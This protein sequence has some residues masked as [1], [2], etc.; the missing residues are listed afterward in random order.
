M[1]R[2]IAQREGDVQNIF[3]GVMAYMLTYYY[4][5]LPL[6]PFEVDLRRM[7]QA[8]M[9]CGQN[10]SIAFIEV[11]GQC[12]ENLMGRG[13]GNP[14]DLTGSWLG[15]PDQLIADT[16]VQKQRKCEIQVYVCRQYLA[17]HFEDLQLALRMS[18]KLGPIFGS[19]N[20]TGVFV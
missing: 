4:S 18:D 16:R 3:L 15:D 14:T 2:T 9:E 11:R 5:G 12:L 1:E 6:Q 10:L 7:H 17:Y 20:G 8:M 19:P 13:T